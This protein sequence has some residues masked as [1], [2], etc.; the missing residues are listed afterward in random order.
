[1][2]RMFRMIALAARQPRA[3]QTISA[4]VSIDIKVLTDLY[5]LLRRRSIDMKVLTDLC[6]ILFILN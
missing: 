3:V 1:M 5:S 4:R 6:R 2:H